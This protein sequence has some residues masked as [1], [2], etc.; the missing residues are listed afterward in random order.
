MLRVF[1]KYWLPIALWTALIFTASG[2]RQS[3]QRSSRIIGPLVRWMFPQMAEER[4]NDIVTGVRKGAHVTEYAI[5]AWLLWRAFRRPVRRDSRPWSWNVA[6]AA[7]IC[8]VLFATSDEFHQAFVPNREA[9]VRDVFIDATGAALALVAIWAVGR[10][11][12]RW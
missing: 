2:D 4:V 1:L 6:L 7:W 11:R 10:W 5:L 12:K 3:S 8:A 9:S